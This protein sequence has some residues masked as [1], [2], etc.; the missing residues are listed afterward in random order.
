MGNRDS[1]LKGHTQNLTCSKMHG[2][3]SHWKGAWSKPTCSSWRASCRGRRQLKLTLGTQMQPF[4]G[5]QP[6]R[7]ALALASTALE[8]SLQLISAGNY[9][10]TSQSAPVQGCPRPGAPDG[11][12]L[13]LTP[14]Q[15]GLL[16]APALRQ[17]TP[18]P[19]RWPRTQPHPPSVSTSATE[20]SAPQSEIP[21]HS[22]T[23]GMT[24]V[25]ERGLTHLWQTPAP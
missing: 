24:L 23:C 10:P 5:G 15:K 9:L 3:S 1:T 12:G 7:M 13:D 6:T 8:Y 18:S 19:T 25:L 21:G 2:R 4:Q 20:P 16:E 22:S 17:D 11:Q 14:Q